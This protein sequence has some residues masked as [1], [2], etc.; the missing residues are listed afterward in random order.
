[1]D[2]FEELEKQTIFYSTLRLDAKERKDVLFFND[3][4]A[5]HRPLVE[6]DVLDLQCSAKEIRKKVKIAEKK[7]LLSKTNR[8]SFFMTVNS[9]DVSKLIQYLLQQNMDKDI[10]VFLSRTL[11]QILDTI[12]EQVTL[13]TV[14]KKSALSGFEFDLSVITV[15]K[16]GENSLFGECHSYSQVKIKENNHCVVC[17]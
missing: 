5:T 12:S 6:I 10:L 8:D 2:S 13:F 15:G 14:Q 9:K 3:V 7:N 4:L 17:L 11:P 1:M 16:K